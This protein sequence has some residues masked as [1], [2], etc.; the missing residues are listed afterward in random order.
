[1]LCIFYKNI[2][3]KMNMNYLNSVIIGSFRK[4][5]KEILALKEQL[6]QYNVRVLSPIDSVILDPNDEFIVFAS[7]PVSDPKILQDSVFVK[8]RNSAFIVVAN[9]GG[10]LGQATIMEIGYAIAYG[11]PIYTLEA[12]HGPHLIPYCKLFTELNMPLTPE[13]KEELFQL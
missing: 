8:I 9:I 2:E 6:E 5:L 1:M 7:D 3:I 13:V 10:Y 4:H 12:V 11:I